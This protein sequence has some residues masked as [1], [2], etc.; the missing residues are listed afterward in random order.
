MG[1]SYSRCDRG[2]RNASSSQR[3]SKSNDNG[4]IFVSLREI[5]ISASTFD[6]LMARDGQQIE[7]YRQAYENGEDMVRVVLRPRFDGGYNVED[8][9]HRV[10][11]A[12]LAEAGLIE[13][14]II[15]A[16]G[17]EQNEDNWN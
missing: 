11:A 8:G 1:K 16:V 2:R 13:A 7:Q 4:T 15:G 17:Q 14:L 5:Y 6:K 10:I 12:K 3:N 9:R